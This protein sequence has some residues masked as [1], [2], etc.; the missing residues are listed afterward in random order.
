MPT[1]TYDFEDGTKQGW[2]FNS[3]DMSVTTTH[4]RGTYSIG[5]QV[6]SVTPVMAEI[7]PS[8][9]SGGKKLDFVIFW[10]YETQ[11][12]YGGGL[13][14]KD[15]NDNAVITAVTNNPG[16]R[17]L[18][19]NGDNKV[20]GG[21][22]DTWYRVK[23][24]LDWASGT[25]DVIWQPEGGGQSTYSNRPLINNTDVEKL[26]LVKYDINN[27][28]IDTLDSNFYHWTDDIQFSYP[29]LNTTGEVFVTSNGIKQTVPTGVL[30]TK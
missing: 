11:S 23:F 9:L 26:E 3:N 28:G 13:R 25:A 5:A 2:T 29:P 27:G 10:Y 21:N 16:Q 15:S 7:S 22:Y 14:L 24:E 12:S 4:A 8:E 20:S 18:D 17:I 30:D 6:S 19:G 1:K